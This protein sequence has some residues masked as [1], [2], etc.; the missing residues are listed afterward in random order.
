[1]T[2]ILTTFLIVFDT[3]FTVPFNVS[4]VSTTKALWL[5]HHPYFQG[6]FTYSL[7]DNCCLFGCC[8]HTLGLLILLSPMLTYQEEFSL[9]EIFLIP[10]TKI[11]PS[12]SFGN[13]PNLHVLAIFCNVARNSDTVCSLSSV[14]FLHKTCTFLPSRVLLA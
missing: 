13:A 11:S 6:T 1:M 5:V 2:L 9:F 3:M 14:V 10:Q 12:A 4:Q 7:C 8:L